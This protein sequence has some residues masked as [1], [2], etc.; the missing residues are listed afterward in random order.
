MLENACMKDE[1]PTSVPSSISQKDRMGSLS[2]LSSALGSPIASIG[3]PS[4]AIPGVIDE[5]HEES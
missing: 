2:G 1:P 4:T 5:E 3:S